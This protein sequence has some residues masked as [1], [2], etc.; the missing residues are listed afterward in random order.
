MS[1]LVPIEGGILGGVGIVLGLPLGQRLAASFV[2]LYQSEEFTLK[3]IIF[4][5]TYLITVLA[6]LLVLLVSEI[7]SLRHISRL[8]LADTTKDWTS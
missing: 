2:N 3:A 7:P 5:S 4:P 6:L 8:N 1:A